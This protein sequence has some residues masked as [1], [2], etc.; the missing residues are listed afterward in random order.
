MILPTPLDDTE[1]PHHNKGEARR[2]CCVAGAVAP[3]LYPTLMDNEQQQSMQ[4]FTGTMNMHTNQSPPLVVNFDDSFKQQV[5]NKI[6]QTTCTC[7]IVFNMGKP[8][9]FKE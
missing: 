7:N 2:S 5:S 3:L 6:T 8:T 9:Q 1:K 4:Q